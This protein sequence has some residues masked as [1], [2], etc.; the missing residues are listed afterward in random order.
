MSE[1]TR[2]DSHSHRHKCQN[3][4]KRE[5]GEDRLGGFQLRGARIN[6][7]TRPAK[8]KPVRGSMTPLV[9]RPREKQGRSQQYSIHRENWKTQPSWGTSIL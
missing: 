1:G 2:G 4:M 9:R 7:P 5:N 3:V 8:S 6:Q